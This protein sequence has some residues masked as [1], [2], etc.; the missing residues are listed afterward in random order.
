MPLLKPSAKDVF[1]KSVCLELAYG[2]LQKAQEKYKKYTNEDPTMLETR[3]DV[4]LKS[5]LS[6]VEE[7]NQD[8]FKEGVT[9][10]K[11][12]TD[13]D[14]WKINVFKIISDKLEQT[15]KHDDFLG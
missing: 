3:E 5:T 4:F 11:R 12:F 7:K 14:K 1:F 15:E 9:A 10:F 2:D 6:A 13:F 8:M